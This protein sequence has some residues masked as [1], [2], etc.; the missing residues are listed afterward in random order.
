MSKRERG[1]KKG[2]EG[3]GEE[4]SRGLG[5]T[6][7]KYTP[8]AARSKIWSKLKMYSLFNSLLFF[9]LSLP[10]LFRRIFAVSLGFRG[11]IVDIFV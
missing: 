8:P 11:I 7:L 10:V 6:I 5:H 1:K 9:V 4:F 2:G 3:G